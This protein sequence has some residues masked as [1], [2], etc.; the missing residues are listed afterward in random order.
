MR[1]WLR[2]AVGGLPTAYWYLWTGLLINRVGGFAVLYLSLYLTAARG[3]GA[4]LAGLVVG[5]HGIGGVLGTLAGGVLTDRWGRRATLL[6]SHLACSAV[7]VALAVSTPL[8]LIAGLCLLLGLTQAMPG[9]AFVAAITDTVPG[10]HRLRAFNLQFWAFNLGTAG[11]SLLAGLLARWSYPGLFLLDA[12]STL[13]TAVIIARKV[14]ETL[15]RAGRGG[16]PGGLRTVL[17]DRIFLAFVGLTVLQALLSSQANT[18]VPLA[19]HADGLGP[20]DYGLVTALGGALIV[21]GQLFVPGLIDGRRKARVLALAMLVTAAGFGTLTVADSL[22]AYLGA[23]AVWTVGGMLAAPPNAAI[24]SEL[25]PPLLRGRYQAVF[26]LSFPFASFVAPALGGAGLE[27][28]GPGLWP[29]VAG[30]GIVA[31]ALHLAAGPARERRTAR[32]AAAPGP[33][34]RRPTAANRVDP[35]ATDGRH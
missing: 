3:A 16:A 21:L 12:A 14:P 29:I 30:V 20:G 33:A 27:H 7:L 23:A 24:N 8:P 19:M 25:A 6:W 18:I 28:L 2:A 31:A 26:Y 9:P 5:A 34:H 10:E 35:Q 11:A 4:A 15:G 32:T 17:A 22:P 13:I 1:G